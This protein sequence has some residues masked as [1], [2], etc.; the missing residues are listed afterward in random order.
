MKESRQWKDGVELF[1]DNRQIFLLFFASA[2]VLSLVFALGV[3]VGKRTGDNPPTQPAT[4]PLALLDQ[5]GGQEK[6]EE[7]L[8]FHDVLG[9]EDKEE[10]QAHSD[11][12]TAPEE[13]GKA[14][15]SPEEEPAPEPAPEPRSKPA[16]KPRRTPEAGEKQEPKQKLAASKKRQAKPVA[17]VGK[18]V[19]EKGKGRKEEEATDEEDKPGKYSL[20][21][22]SFQDR[23]EAELFMGKREALPRPR[24]D[25]G[26]WRLVPGPHRRLHVLGRGAGCQAELRARPEDHRL[27]GQELSGAGQRSLETGHGPSIRSWLIPTLL[28]PV[29]RV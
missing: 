12:A 16:R 21:L 11:A 23:T 9:K 10:R 5:M 20:Q 3:V 4:D 2:V 24:Q 6:Q 27:R 28:H 25:P 18:P 1:L 8:T 15:V 26:P 17:M 13:E 22:S 19:K 7:N 29:I 14:K